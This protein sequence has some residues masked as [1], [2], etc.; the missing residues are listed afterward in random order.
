MNTIKI[1]SPL[2]PILERTVVNFSR[3]EQSEKEGGGNYPRFRSQFLP[4]ARAHDYANESMKMSG[5]HTV[6]CHKYFIS[7]EIS[8]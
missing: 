3:D 4:H 1:F 7:S 6:V 5:S 2:N 8:V